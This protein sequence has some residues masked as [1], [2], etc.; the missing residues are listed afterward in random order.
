MGWQKITHLMPVL[1][2]IHQKILHQA[3][4]LQSKWISYRR[5]FHQIAELSWHEENTISLILNYLSKIEKKL[6][7]PF[8]ITEFKGGLSVDWE[9]DPDYNW[10]LFRSDIDALPILEKTDLPFSSFNPGVMHACGHDFHIAMMLGAIEIIES[11]EIKPLINIRF[12]FQRAEETGTLNCGGHVLVQEGI[13]NN[14]KSAYALHIS[15][16]LEKGVFFSRPGTF[17][18]NTTTIDFSVECSGGHVM[19]PHEGSN[20]I[21]ILADILASLKGIEIRILNPLSQIT[22]VPTKI[23]SGIASNIRPNVGSLSLALRNFLSPA[24]L[25]FLIEGIRKKIISIVESYPTAKVV[26]FDVKM[27]YP[28]LI[29]HL[30]SYEE[31]KR[32]IENQFQVKKATPIFAGEDFAYYLEQKPGAYWILG[33]KNGSGHDHHTAD[34][35]PDESVLSLGVA[36]WLQLAYSL[37]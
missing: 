27:G 10:V 6:K 4:F 36:F 35:N 8:K 15:G 18:A 30:D 9:F 25:D 33:A 2:D 19:H 29:N 14:I 37:S 16:N 7:K 17:L 20:A 21:D 34:F 26:N 13:L 11:S 32:A 23:Q 31:S 28:P 1:E 24:E 3:T 5:E 12:V 22:I